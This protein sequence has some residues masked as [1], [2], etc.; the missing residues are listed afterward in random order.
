MGT[1]QS[2]RRNRY[3]KS[4]DSQVES[5]GVTVNSS[6]IQSTLSTSPNEPISLSAYQQD[7]IK[8]GYPT[9]HPGSY[10]NSLDNTSP[11]N[12]PF[13][14][15]KIHTGPTQPGM[16]FSGLHSNSLFLPK[17]WE[18]QDG[19]YAKYF[20]LKS[21]FEDIVLPVVASS[22]CGQPFA[23]VADFG[24][25]SGSWLTEMALQYDKWEFIGIPV[26]GLLGDSEDANVAPETMVLPN[27][28]IDQIL[29]NDVQSSL[30]DSS[31]DLVNIWAP[32][33]EFGNSQWTHVL[34]EAYRVLKPGGY[35]QI[36][37]LHNVPVGTVLIKS[38]IDT[39]RNILKGLDKDYDDAIRLKT[40]LPAA[41]FQ[42]CQ[43]IKKHVKLGGES[44]LGQE[45]TAVNLR[46]FESA[47]K[48]L[49]P[50]M[51]LD[52]DDYQHRVEMV[53]AQCVQYNA[54]MDWLGYV[55]K[56]PLI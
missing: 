38:F 35:I 29:E 15:R 51:G 41:G 50:R 34:Q 17:D 16:D 11:Q 26:S 4:T 21:L 55:A 42:L 27:V 24:C 45:F 49:A 22:V 44:T 3:P 47:Q 14:A 18:A 36:V 40:L 43:C 30:E 25:G 32:G 37:E 13:P 56:K 5:S 23:R 1:V 7:L 33:L 39:V 54:H 12:H 53:C 19:Q 9:P 6:T 28:R 10:P 2:K 52:R 46:I 48:L 8:Q 20:A 31:V